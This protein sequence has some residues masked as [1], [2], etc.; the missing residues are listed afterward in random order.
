MRHTTPPTDVQELTCAERARMGFDRLAAVFGREATIR[1]ARAPDL[2]IDHGG[3]CMVAR[4]SGT[5]SY[6]RGCWLMNIDPR[7]VEAKMLGFDMFADDL[8]GPIEGSKYDLEAKELR[9]EFRAL[10]YAA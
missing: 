4:A 7:G 6:G 5:Y 9:A 10:G 1:A 3:K 8:D 2:D